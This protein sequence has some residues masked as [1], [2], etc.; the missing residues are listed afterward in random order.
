MELLYNPFLLYAG[1][2]L[3][4][5]GVALALPRRG[6]SPQALGGLIAAVGAGLILL[7]IA[8]VVRSQVP[9]L[10]FYIFGF[11]A[12]AASLRVISH[13]RPVYAALYFILTILASAGLY[14][15]LSAEFMTFALVI[16]YAGAILIT[17]LFVIM[18][19]TEAPQAE[20]IEALAGYDRYSRE[21]VWATIFGFLLLAAFTVMLGRGAAGLAPAGSEVPGDTLVAS[22][23]GKLERALVD[24]GVMDLK[25]GDRV[26]RGEEGVID[27]EART[28]VVEYGQGA[29]QVVD[30]PAGVSVTNTEKVGFE[31]LR[32][33]PGAIE[34]AGVILLMAMVG[35]VVLARKKVE[36]DEDAKLRAMGRR[37]EGGEA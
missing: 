36:M 24:A 31:L 3:G 19:A 30:W 11:I 28:V 4:A 32:A 23:P 12:V 17:Y 29:R 22:M 25:A 14:L 15:L 16:V 33:K 18:L 35:A 7:A 1:C 2:A 10:F 34:I 9:N 8:P 37:L 26:P 21:P 20:Q 13:P 27:V 5:L 6:L